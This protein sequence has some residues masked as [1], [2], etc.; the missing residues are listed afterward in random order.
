[1]ELIAVD[2]WIK[3]ARPFHIMRDHPYHMELILAGMWGGIAGVLPNLQRLATSTPKFMRNR[4]SDQEF[5]R[6]AV[7]PLIKTNAL[8]HDSYYRHAGAID[9][10]PYCR[11]PRPVHVGGAVKAMKPFA[12]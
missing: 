7:W 12:G 10:P 5:L 11:L 8:I 1:M 4:W 2:D 9:F 6:D 3:S